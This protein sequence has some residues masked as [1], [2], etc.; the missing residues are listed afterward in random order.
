MS[1]SGERAAAIVAAGFAAAEK[2]IQPGLRETDVAAS[3]QME[4]DT[5]AEAEAVKRSYGSLYCMSGPKSAKAAAA[6]ARTRERRLEAGD[7]V[8]I[9]ANTCADGFWT[10]VTRTY[11]VERPA[12]DRGH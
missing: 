1:W 7:L 6:F 11:T 2:S 5:S 10:D 8:M 9:H 4:I 3:I 12:S